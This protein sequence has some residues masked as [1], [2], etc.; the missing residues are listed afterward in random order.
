MCHDIEG[1]SGWASHAISVME[2]GSIFRALFASAGLFIP[3]LE[4]SALDAL[5]V[6]KM[7][8]IARAD[9]LVQVPVVYKG[10]FA[11]LALLDDRIPELSFIASA[12]LSWFLDK[13]GSFGASNALSF[14]KERFIR[15]AFFTD[16]E[17]IV[18]EF[19]LSASKA[20]NS[21]KVG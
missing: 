2:V 4:L 6:W 16:F 5:S 11:A 7:G 10:L 15:W 19:E 1:S 21:I 18:P 20:L 17:L 9:A 14:L 13:V 8:Q 12:T 3:N